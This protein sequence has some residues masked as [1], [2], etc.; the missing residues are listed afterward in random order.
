MNTELEA[1]QVEYDDL[2]L[3]PEKSDEDYARIQA[4]EDRL[5]SRYGLYVFNGEALD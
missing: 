4:I 5:A 2:L 1:M 3:R